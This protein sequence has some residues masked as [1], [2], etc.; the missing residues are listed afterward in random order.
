MRDLSRASGVSQSLI[1]HHFGSKHDL[2]E[3][4]KEIAVKRFREA[5]ESR[6]RTR[7]RD[8]GFLAG[9]LKTFFDFLGENQTLIR[10]VA[11]SRLEGET[12]LWP[13]E[14][15]MLRSLEEE[16]R[17]VQESKIIRSDVEPV[18]LVLMIG[19]LALFW[20]E[21]RAIIENLLARLQKNREADSSYLEQV[22]GVLIRGLSVSPTPSK[23]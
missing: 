16:I 11:W 15:E 13:G 19:A 2:Y 17:R 10:L 5:W 14:E 3:A 18:F 9:V 23:G 1:H 20:W 6:R 7:E 22:S 4:V 21:N 8:R 12:S